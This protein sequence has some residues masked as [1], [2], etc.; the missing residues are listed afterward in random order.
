MNTITADSFTGLIA[1]ALERMAFV[2][3]EPT[4]ESPAEVL[5][6]SVAHASIELEGTE[7]YRVSVSVSPGI[8]REVAAGMMGLD[9][10]EVDVDDH[11]R[12][13]VAELA[14]IFGGELVMLLT[15]GESQMS[16]GLPKDI[17][18]DTA[19]KLLDAAQ[20]HGFVSVLHGD[21]GS[22]A[23]AVRRF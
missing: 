12:A 21:G 5:V 10:E 19:G 4:D 16:L 14:N 6:R 13:T 9:A 11:A 23:V 1:V 22:L 8:V 17:D 20:E 7:R 3:L 15:G 2:V 18:D